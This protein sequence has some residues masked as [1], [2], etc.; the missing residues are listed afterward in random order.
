MLLSGD[1]RRRLFKDPPV[2]WPDV[3][4]RSQTDSSVVILQGSAGT[5]TP[6]AS[7]G[8]SESQRSITCITSRTLWPLNLQIPHSKK[9]DRLASCL[10]LRS[11]VTMTTLYIY[12][13]CIHTCDITST[14]WGWCDLKNLLFCTN[15]LTKYSFY[16]FV[17]SLMTKEKKREGHRGYFTTDSQR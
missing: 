6:E 12:C 15:H 5:N 10:Q 3:L 16:I 7:N 17:V 11:S 4:L 1:E 9:S 2:T 14:T 8:W 13:K